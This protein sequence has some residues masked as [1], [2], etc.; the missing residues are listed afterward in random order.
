MGDGWQP[1][2]GW[3][4]GG[5]IDP[6]V[7][8]R[9]RLATMRWIVLSLVFVLAGMPVVQATEA[10]CLERPAP[11]TQPTHTEASAQADQPP[12]HA[13]VSAV[14]EVDGPEL[15]HADC[16]QGAACMSGVLAGAVVPLWNL[17]APLADSPRRAGTRATRDGITAD[18]IRPPSLT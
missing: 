17:A 12:C 3:G 9:V 4:R 8:N 1:V 11:P 2:F 6:G 7:D 18:L 13:L 5:R 14:A 15:P 10:C 16:A